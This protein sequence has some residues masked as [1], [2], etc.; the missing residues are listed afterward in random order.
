MIDDV[1]Q[2]Q[3]SAEA[4]HPG[5]AASLSRS[6]VL[7]LALFGQWSEFKSER[8]FYCY[9]HTHLRAAFPTLPCREQLNRL[10]RQQHDAL[11]AVSQMLVDCLPE[12]HGLYERAHP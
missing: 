9:A 12:L 1:C 10:I 6:E 7:T 11:V 2:Q 5:P 4:K 8:G 3:M